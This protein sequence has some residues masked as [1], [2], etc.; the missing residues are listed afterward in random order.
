MSQLVESLNKFSLEAFQTLIKNNP[1]ANTVFSPYSAFVSV[2]MTVS[3]F[4]DTTRSEILHALQFPNSKEQIDTFL[5]QLRELISNESTKTVFSSNRIWAN[6]CVNI[7][8]QTFLPNETKLGIPILKVDFPQP[9]CDEI[10]NE[11]SRATRG[12]IKDI[13]NPDDLNS[14]TETAFLLVNAIYFKAKWQCDF[15]YDDDYDYNYESS[16]SNKKNFTLANGEKI[17]ANMIISSD[18]FEYFENRHFKCVSIPYTQNEYDFVIVIPKENDGYKILENL[19]FDQLNSNLLTKM[20]NKKLILIMPEF[21]IESKFELNEIFKQLGLVN[22]FQYTAE[23]TDKKVAYKIG[24]II[25]KAKIIVNIEGTE[26]AAATFTEAMTTG[27]SK[28]LYID[29]PFFYFIRNKITNSILFEG[30]VNDP[31]A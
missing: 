9:G 22:A 30:F 20:K 4:R 26:A 6:K 28:L 11:V 12:M 15:E 21:K 31:R 29:H 25:Q 24:K 23:C 10:N 27:C 1:N 13:V 5:S 2:A 8:P 19:T 3:L 16:S 7:S 14:E 18:K 17:F